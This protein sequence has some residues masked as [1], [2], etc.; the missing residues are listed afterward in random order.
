MTRVKTKDAKQA[1]REVLQAKAKEAAGSNNL[2]SKNS[3][4][5]KLEPFLR[6]AE[7]DV[8]GAGPRGARV[9]VEAVVSRAEANAEAVWEKANPPVGPG[10]AFLSTAEVE[11]IERADP[12]LG[13]LTRMAHLKA[14]RGGNAETAVKDFFEGF[15]F[16]QDDV[17]AHFPQGVRVDAREGQP[18]R[19]ELPPA[20]LAVFDR[21]G[22]AEQA[23]WASVSA[24]R[25]KIGT[26]DVWILYT[27]TDG[28]DASLEVFKK[29]GT[30][31][32]SAKLYAA[33]ML[34][35][36]P[37]VGRA[38]FAPI[39]TPL[40]NARKDEGLSEPADRIAAGQLPRDWTPMV[41][42]DAGHVTHRDNRFDGLAVPNP[43]TGEMQE[44]AYAAL[45]FLWDGSFKHRMVEPAG[46][47]LGRLREGVLKL[48]TFTRPDDGKTYLVA[49]WRDI[50]DGSYVLYFERSPAGLKLA[51]EQF[52]N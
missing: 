6:R 28:D 40:D 41:T 45:E 31:L 19:A 10:G 8:R 18:G 5:P 43:P 13:Q 33:E 20:V 47:E 32:A 51:I 17:R 42:L 30:P 14:K 1:L 49:D 22:R 46:L 48:G 24:H 12:A 16:A 21:Y 26:H 50:D 27:S 36:D 37:F 4:A 9:S 29:D 3:E 2:I 52:D 34:G 44:L 39:F 11:R 35:W 25:A 7:Q 38:R 15:D 23:D